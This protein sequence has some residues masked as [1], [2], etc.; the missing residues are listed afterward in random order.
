VLAPSAA[1]QFE[2]IVSSLPIK[3]RDYTLKQHKSSSHKRQVSLFFGAFQSLVMCGFGTK[4]IKLVCS[5]Y[6]YKLNKIE[7]MIDF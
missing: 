6:Q 4:S 7:L 5:I 2:K 3:W 1:K